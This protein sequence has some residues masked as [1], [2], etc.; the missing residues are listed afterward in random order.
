MRNPAPDWG[1]VAGDPLPER[2]ALNAAAARLAAGASDAVTLRAGYGHRGAARRRR[3]RADRGDA[4]QRRAARRSRS[5]ASSRSTAASATTALYR[6]LQVHECYATCGPMNL[7]AALLGE[8]GA[9]GDCLAVAA[10][11]P[12]TL[13]NPEPGFFILGAKSYGRSSRFLLSV[14]WRQVDDVFGTLI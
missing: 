6:Q 10:H 4:A 3:R 11:G 9:G 14:G 12:D 13:R 7:A 5:T 1:A 2:A 8:A